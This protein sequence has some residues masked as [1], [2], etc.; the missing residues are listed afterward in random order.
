MSYICQ[1]AQTKYD[2]LWSAIQANEGTSGEWLTSTQIAA[3]LIVPYAINPTFETR[4]D[5]NPR[6]AAQRW[7]WKQK[8]T[9]Q[10]GAHAQVKWISNGQHPYTGVFKGSDLG[11]ARLSTAL[12]PSTVDNLPDTAQAPNMALKFMRGS[13]DESSPEH[14]WDSAHMMSMPTVEGIPKEW[15]FFSHDFTTTLPYPKPDFLVN[16][17]KI[18]STFNKYV[19]NLGLSDF[20]SPKPGAYGEGVFPFHVRFEP[21]SDVAT[22]FPSE[23][24]KGGMLFMEQL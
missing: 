20:G 5:A 14:C 15:N 8:W 12:M 16:V 10:I 3:G 19:L 11:I 6:R 24:T 17:L 22:L 18:F 23:F 13:A 21:H 1:D 9:H 2:E 4:G 7:K